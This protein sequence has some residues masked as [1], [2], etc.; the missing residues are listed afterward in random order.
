MMHRVFWLVLLVGSLWQQQAVAEQSN[1]SKLEM[2]RELDPG[3][4]YSN[5]NFIDA[6]SNIAW[7]S[8]GTELAAY[9]AF[10]NLVTIWSVD[11]GAVLRQLHR[12]GAVAPVGRALAFVAGD[13]EIVTP[14]ASGK[15]TSVA[16]SVF[17]TANG[18][19]LREIA[20]PYPDRAR[21]VN[22]ATWLVSSPDQTI[23]AV[24]YGLA[25]PQP[26]AM[27]ATRTWDKL[28]VLPEGPKNEFEAPT[29]L[30]FSRDGKQLAVGRS[31][32]LVFVYDTEN[33]RVLRRLEVRFP[34]GSVDWLAFN[35]DSSK[36]VV[37]TGGLASIRY[38]KDGTKQEFF[39]QVRVLDAVDGKLLATY[40][41][42][43]PLTVNRSGA[44][45]PDG[46][47][48]AFLAGDTL[49]VWDPT[50]PDNGG[51]EIALKHG[52]VSLAFSPD[53]TKLAVENGRKVAI[54]GL[55]H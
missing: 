55:T 51:Q 15:S 44:W 38:S 36:V 26:V 43:A 27:Y 7:S 28:A 42:S 24:I 39:P 49:Y 40:V 12:P 47:F 31:D 21:N 35:P 2:V 30:A 11:D 52:A 19:I 1:Q 22:G 54:F 18:E 37:G 6:P 9:T 13:E 33:Y 8:D 46:H 20:G 45:G 29:A 50:Q 25:L 41:G 4:D 34:E 16:F 32:R 5:A 23:L 48:I 3:R 10:G 17:D 14:P 53:G